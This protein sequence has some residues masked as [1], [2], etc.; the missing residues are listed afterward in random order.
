MNTET[1]A[2]LNKGMFRTINLNVE[3]KKLLFYQL[4]SPLKNVY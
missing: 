4:S 2:P 3:K 1:N